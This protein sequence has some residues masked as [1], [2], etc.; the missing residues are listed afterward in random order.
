MNST[1]TF[2]YIAYLVWWRLSA[3]PSPSMVHY[4]TGGA[5]IF[6]IG[7]SPPLLVDS[8]ESVL[9]DLQICAPDGFFCGSHSPRVGEFNELLGLQFKCDWIM[10]RKDW[11]S[12]TMFSVYFD[13]CSTVTEY[14]YWCFR[15][16]HQHA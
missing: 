9:D 6:N 4:A 1:S 5:L 2:A 12:E 16:M 14:S 7:S 11:T 8:V 15:H 10:Q 13:S 3:R